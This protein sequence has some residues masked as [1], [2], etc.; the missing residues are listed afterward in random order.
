MTPYRIRLGLTLVAAAAC[1]LATLVVLW[2][3]LA[4]YDAAE[5]TSPGAAPRTSAPV[6]PSARAGGTPTLAEFE[7]VWDVDLRR[8]LVDPAPAVTAS[9]VIRAAQ[10]A[11]PIGLKLAGTVVE[12]GHSM[13]VFVTP[14]GKS[15]LKAVGDKAGNA[16]VVDIQSDRVTLR[17]N[18][19]PVT[20]K[21]EKG[22]KP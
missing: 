18:G 16:E 14:A 17:Y 10:A 11:A 5:D 9:S 2:G 3:L 12:P 8:P 6:R 1:G 15:E 4:P 21:V 22:A 19:S 13:A 20:L 7:E